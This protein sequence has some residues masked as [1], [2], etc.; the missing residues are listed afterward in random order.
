LHAQEYNF[1]N[2]G[3]TEGL[4]NLAIRQ[5]YQDRVG[6]IWV[7]T[8]NG[9]FRYDGERFEAFGPEQGILPTSGAAFGD[10]PDGSLLVGGDFGLYQLSGNRFEKLPVVFKTVSWAQGIRSDGKGHTFIGTDSG[11]V[12]RLVAQQITALSR[13]ARKGAMPFQSAQR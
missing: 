12:E 13:N 7:S 6:F 9:I 2:F 3:V 11:L 4:N 10:A 8:E 1:R 5:V